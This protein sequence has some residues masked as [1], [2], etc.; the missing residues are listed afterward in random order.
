MQAV[1]QLQRRINITPFAAWLG[2]IVESS[3]EHSLVLRLCLRAEFQGSPTT[4]DLHGGV[5]ASLIDTATSYVVMA[6]TGRSVVTIDMRVDYH[7]PGSSSE[8]RV[9]GSIVRLGKTL[10]T[11]DAQIR[12]SGGALVA[13]GRALVMHVDR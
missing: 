2:L 8:Y 5:T 10:A 12:D 9:K 13:S 4:Q 3:D 7:R 6:R 1:E 11:A